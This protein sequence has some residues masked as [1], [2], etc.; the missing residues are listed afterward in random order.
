MTA[1]LRLTVMGPLRLWRGD[2]ELDAGPRQQR[3][4]LAL[5]LVREGRPV[6]I[7]D[8]VNLLWGSEPPLSAVNNIHKY[9]GSLRRLLEPGLPPRSATRVI[10]P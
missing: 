4:L 3:C 6:S 5:L 8:L 7:N 9:V 2:A 1:R 10:P